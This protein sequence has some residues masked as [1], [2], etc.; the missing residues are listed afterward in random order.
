MNS[1]FVVASSVSLFIENVCQM[2][3]C[4]IMNHTSSGM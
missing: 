3:S 2:K 4:V 1:R